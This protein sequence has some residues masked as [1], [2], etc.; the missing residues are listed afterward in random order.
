MSKKGNKSKTSSGGGGV[1]NGKN[2]SYTYQTQEEYMYL[3]DW[4][5]AQ[6]TWN[7]FNNNNSTQKHTIIFDSNV[8]NK[9]NAMLV[10]KVSYN[11]FQVKFVKFNTSFKME[12]ALLNDDY[13]TVTLQ[14]GEGLSAFIT[15]ATFLA[16]EKKIEQSKES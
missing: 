1:Y 11:N 16:F 4:N 12:N 5:S 3:N 13:V 15:R 14:S 7:L 6:A 9:F 2:D 10:K 8:S